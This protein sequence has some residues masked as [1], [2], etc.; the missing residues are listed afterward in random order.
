MEYIAVGKSERYS[1]EEAVKEASLQIKSVL[2]GRKISLIIILHTRDYSSNALYNYA[3]FML[4]PQTCFNLYSP[5]LIFQN[6]L[7]TQGI[8]IFAV[9]HP[10]IKIEKLAIYDYD[11]EKLESTLRKLK[12]PDFLVWYLHKNIP[13]NEIVPIFKFVFG[14][15]YKLLGIY[16]YSSPGEK[17]ERKDS[18]TISLL[19][20]KGK[21]DMYFVKASGFLPICRTFKITKINHRRSTITEINNQP[22]SMVYEKYLGKLFPLFTKKK[23]STIYPIGIIKE[24]TYYTL[25]IQDIYDDGSLFY[26]GDVKE[27][28][29]GNLLL[30]NP[31]TLLTNLKRTLEEEHNNIKKYRWAIIINSIIRAEILKG[32]TLTEEAEVIKSFLPNTNIIGIYMD[33]SIY[34]DRE[35]ND[36][37]I[38]AYNIKIIFLN[39]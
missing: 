20:F 17:K 39:I 11:N 4:A 33:F 30:A 10:N 19:S 23:Y 26:I 13:L 8:I 6:K 9:A 21:L 27:K 36:I 38:D 25:Y 3:R 2:G 31:L 14:K 1:V 35:L 34:P 16:T 15:Y 32:E 12:K 7:L 29:N 28:N 22:A 37:I 18:P 24:N 5:Y